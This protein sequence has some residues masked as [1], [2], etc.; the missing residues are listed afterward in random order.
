MQDR[1]LAQMS[2]RNHQGDSRSARPW[3]WAPAA[4]CAHPREG[5]L[6]LAAGCRS[7]SGAG[8]PTGCRAVHI[9]GIIRLQRWGGTLTP[10]LEI[11]KGRCTICGT[12]QSASAHHENFLHNVLSFHSILAVRCPVAKGGVLLAMQHAFHTAHSIE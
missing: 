6:G 7:P 3:P 5:G 9:Y 10:P 4:D 2:C 12:G 8:G 11:I 1:V